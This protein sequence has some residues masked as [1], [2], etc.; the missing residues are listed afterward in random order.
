MSQFSYFWPK[1][2]Q[3][4]FFEFLALHDY[5]EGLML[6]T[7]LIA[8]IFS[9]K[10]YRQHRSLRI[11]SYYFAFFLVAEGMEFYFYISP[12]GDRFALLLATLW[13]DALTIFEFCVFSLVI[14]HY[15]VGAGRR[16]AVK[17]NTVIFFIAEI[18]VF[19]QTFPRNSII[20][21]GLLEAAAIVPPCVIYYYELFT[22]MN[23]KALKDRPSFWVVTGIICQGIC[24]SSLILSMEYMG[25][26]GDGAYNF[27]ILFYC[28]LFVLLMRAY[29]SSPEERVV[30]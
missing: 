26:F 28:I 9:L 7:T 11:L 2:L 24:N 5:F 18:I 19:F 16:L 20:P 4:K 30:A 12:K 6:F 1:V 29:R 25:R 15:I 14:L 22:S 17:L 13:I 8:F 10:H 27:G 23:T 21:L 3:V